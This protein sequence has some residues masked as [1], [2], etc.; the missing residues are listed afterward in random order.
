M[1]S[2]QQKYELEIQTEAT[3]HVHPDTDSAV[4][5][6]TEDED[7]DD[8]GDVSNDHH[9]RSLSSVSKHSTYFLAYFRMKTPSATTL[10]NTRQYLFHPNGLRRALS[11]LF[12]VEFLH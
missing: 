5:H 3:P 7:E 10:A 9:V 2:A 12:Q 6:M 4:Q 8:N 1:S 11:L